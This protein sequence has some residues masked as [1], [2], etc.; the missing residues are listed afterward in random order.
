[1]NEFLWPLCRFTLLITFIWMS[2]VFF[3]LVTDGQAIEASLLSPQ[4]CAIHIRSYEKK[5]AIPKGLLHAISK[6]ESGRTD[7]TGHIVPW[8]WTINAQGKGYFFPTKQEAIAAVQA[9]QAKGIESIDV[10]CMQI[11]LYYHPHAFKT[12]ED[13]FEPSKNVAYGAH[14]L[15]SLQKDHRSWY[16]AVAHYHSA[17]PDLHIP[18]QKT[19][20]NIWNRDQRGKGA[21]LAEGIFSEQSSNIHMSHIRRL[22]SG[23]KLGLDG[24]R[25][26]TVSHRR[27]IGSHSSHIRRLKL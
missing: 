9:M 20:M 27:R 21:S 17:N 6:A 16:R 11:N 23:K 7:D 12:L 25:L 15:N 19:V 3:L 1:M 22:N 24:G 26:S 4:S 18:Y 14:F 8:P 13:A 2:L 5:H 10:G